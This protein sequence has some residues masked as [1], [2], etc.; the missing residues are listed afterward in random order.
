[1]ANVKLKISSAYHPQPAGQTERV[2]Q[3]M[4]TYLCCFVS[5]CPKQW[6]SWLSLAEFWYNASVHSFIGMFPFEALYSYAHRH[7]GLLADN[8][9]GMSSLDQWIQQRRLMTDLVRQHLNRAT[10][11]KKQQADKRRTER[12]FTIG[13]MVFLKLQPYVQSSLAPRANQKLSFKFFGPFKV[14]QR[15]GTVAYKLELPPS[16]SIHPD[17][18]ISQLKKA[19]GVDHQISPLVP[20]DKLLFQ[21]REKLL[22]RHMVTKGSRSVYQVLVKWSLSPE[23][24]ATWEDLLSLKQKFPGVPAWGQAGPV[25]GGVQC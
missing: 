22:Q 8:S 14:L 24:L 16:S 19:V 10:V 18:H 7:Y 21:V 6:A 17:F 23:S 11:R 9:S 15:V 12:Q 2:N 20:Q 13:E 3:C 25:G 4:E 5:A 1:M